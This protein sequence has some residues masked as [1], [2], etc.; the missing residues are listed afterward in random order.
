V[1]KAFIDSFMSSIALAI[2]V[3]PEGLPAIVTISLALGAREFA[4]R[5][6]LIRKLSLG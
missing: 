5:N 3:V 2:S 1:V 6:A 4:R